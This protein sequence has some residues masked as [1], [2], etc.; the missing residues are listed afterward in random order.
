MLEDARVGVPK[1]PKLVGVA[2]GKG[3]VGG[4]SWD[5]VGGT[6]ENVKG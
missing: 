1:K 5:G 4:V 3:P 6:D 2:P